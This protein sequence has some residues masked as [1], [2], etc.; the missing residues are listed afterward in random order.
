MW[1]VVK[2]GFYALLVISAVVD[3]WFLWWI[4]FFKGF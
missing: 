2:I 1:R 3:A 4:G